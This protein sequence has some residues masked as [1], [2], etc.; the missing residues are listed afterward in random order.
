MEA[1]MGHARGFT[2]IEII[3]V[4]V[5]AGFLGAVVVNL[6]GSQLRRSSSPVISTQDL[7][8]AESDMETVQAFYTHHVNSHTSGTLAEV[9]THFSG[10]ASIAMTPNT[11]GTFTGDTLDSLTVVVTRGDVTLRSILTQERQNAADN[12]VTY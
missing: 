9:Q 7:A 4:I 10:N 8:R 2:L 6:M 3:V 1:S 11:G 12:T 5:V